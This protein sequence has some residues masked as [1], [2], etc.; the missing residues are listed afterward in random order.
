[1]CL[2]RPDRS[3]LFLRPSSR[4][5]PVSYRV[6][7]VV[8]SDFWGSSR[9]SVTSATEYPGFG[10]P[11]TILYPTRNLPSG[12]THTSR[13]TPVSRPRD[14]PPARTVIVLA[15]VEVGVTVRPDPRGTMGQ[16]RRVPPLPPGRDLPPALGLLTPGWGGA[17]DPSDLFV[18]PG[19][20]IR[21]YKS[22]LELRQRVGARKRG[23]QGRR[24]LREKNKTWES[25]NSVQVFFS[26]TLH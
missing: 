15:V 6:R 21:I 2:L 16:L 11:S 4:P 13:R 10:A 20:T 8:P 24:T 23:A 7:H 22:S 5:S 17:Q 12:S 9:I 18:V 1:M 14:R 19:R 3:S 26:K 25:P